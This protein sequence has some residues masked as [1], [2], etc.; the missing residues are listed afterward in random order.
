MSRKEKSKERDELWRI[1]LA[2]YRK[3]HEEYQRTD[4]SDEKYDDI[5]KN[6]DN[7]ENTILKMAIEDRRLKWD[8]IKFGIGTGVGVLQ[9]AATFFVSLVGMDWEQANSMRSRFA[10]KILQMLPNSVRMPTDY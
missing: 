5:C 3:I 8:K 6:L 1:T 9:V 7:M 2:S 10:P 4:P